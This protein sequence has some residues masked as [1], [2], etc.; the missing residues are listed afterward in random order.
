MGQAAEVVCQ[1]GEVLV[2]EWTSGQPIQLS[3]LPDLD[4]PSSD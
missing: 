2:K 4:A 1:V 3:V